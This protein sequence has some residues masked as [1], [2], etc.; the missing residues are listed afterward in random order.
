[1]MKY[2]LSII[3]LFFSVWVHAEALHPIA[4]EK[5][6]LYPN[7]KA[8]IQRGAKFFAN[9][10]MSCHTL[11]YLRFNSL[12]Q[13]AGVVYEKMP[14][15]IKNWYF[16]MTPPDLTLEVRVRGADWVY[17]YLHSFYQDSARQTQVN[18]L[19][20]PNTSMPDILAPLRGIQVLSKKVAH[21]LPRA[22]L[23]W[24]DVLELQQTGS[25]TPEQL[26]QTIAD[27]VNFLAYASEPTKKERID[28]GKWVIVFLGVF[29]I[30]VY[31]LK[32]EYWKDINRREK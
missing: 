22:S 27:V 16:G 20:I 11:I 32:R 3:M 12:A 5:V 9:T 4:L 7:D 23:Q 13:K 14:V 21:T 30:L 2:A 26:D 17:T 18:N 15:G 6:P 19:L 31:L 28:L 24:Y 10:C 25:M 8:S 29:L 1:M